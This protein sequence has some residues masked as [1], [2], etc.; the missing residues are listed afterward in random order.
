MTYSND[1]VEDDISD[2]DNDDEKQAENPEEQPLSVAGRSFN[3]LL[4]DNMII[5]NAATDIASF[6]SLQVIN[7]NS[8]GLNV[9]TL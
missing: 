1:A 4:E 7:T 5:E 8:E 3:D 6:K 9:P 2:E